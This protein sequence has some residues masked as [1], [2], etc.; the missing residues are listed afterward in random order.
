MI[1]IG[2]PGYA[3]GYGYGYPFGGS[4]VQNYKEGTITI[5][6]VDGKKNELLWRGVGEM[7]VNNRN[8]SEEKV[9]QAVTNILREYP[10]KGDR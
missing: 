2:V 4:M 9:Y 7:E 6:F 1:S 3:Y 5:D 8:I 10:P